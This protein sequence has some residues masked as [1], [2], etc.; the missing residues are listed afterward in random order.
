MT[1]H[2]IICTVQGGNSFWL[3][4]IGFVLLLFLSFSHLQRKETGNLKR[5][6]K[7]LC[8]TKLAVANIKRCWAAVSP[9]FLFFFLFFFI[10]YFF[11]H[12]FLSRPVLSCYVWTYVW[13]G[14]LLAAYSSFRSGL[15]LVL[16]N[17]RT[18]ALSVSHPHRTMLPKRMRS[19]IRRRQ[20]EDKANGD[21][22]QWAH[23]DRPNIH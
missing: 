2:L 15:L 6:A 23:E 5:D 18:C 10:F 19:A 17:L 16:E 7:Q 20:K 1:R 12:L 9:P 22:R 13:R 14:C 3:F 4:C 21:D 8:W 11:A